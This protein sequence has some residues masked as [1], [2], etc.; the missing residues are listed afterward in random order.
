MK[1][2]PIALWQPEIGTR[3]VDCERGSGLIIARDPA[4][5]WRNWVVVTFDDDVDGILTY[6]AY[7]GRLHAER[8]RA[9]LHLIRGGKPAEPSSTAAEPA[10]GRAA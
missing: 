5:R 7:V 9:G 3:V 10:T 8:P 1:R 2:S 6:Y 4:R